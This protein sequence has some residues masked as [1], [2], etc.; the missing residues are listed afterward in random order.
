MVSRISSL[1]LFGL[2][3]FSVDVEVDICRGQP[4][5]EIVGLPDASVRES[6][7]RIRSALNSISVVLP[8]KR[9]T[10]N[11][12]PADVKKSGTMHDLAILI[13]ILQSMG[14]ISADLRGKCFIGEVSLSG[15]VRAVNGVLPMA[16]LAPALGVEELYVPMDNAFE[17]SAAEQV[18]VYGVRSVAQLLAHLDGTER[19]QPQPAYQIPADDRQALPDFSAVKGQQSAKRALE[20]AAAGGHNALMIGPPGSGKKYAC[21]AAALNSAGNDTGRIAGN[22]QYLLDFRYAG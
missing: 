10:V 17:A 12:A 22:H 11:L 9:I 6:R 1:G 4:H 14:N 15:E 3:A 7:E 16:L 2:N 20:I 13:G 19:I 8:A 5:F 18:K 21:Q